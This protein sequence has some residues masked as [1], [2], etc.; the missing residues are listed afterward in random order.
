MTLRS[1]DRSRTSVLS[2]VEVLPS[3]RTSFWC[4]P[5]FDNAEMYCWIREAG[6]GASGDTVGGV[7][8]ESEVLDPAACD[9]IAQALQDETE[10]PSLLGLPQAAG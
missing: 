9:I 7:L 10:N 6:A 5:D 8:G 2:I 1:R 4:P 3:K